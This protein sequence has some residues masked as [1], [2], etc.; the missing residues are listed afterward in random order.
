MSGFC[1]DGV[2]CTTACDGPAEQCDLSGREGD[3][4]AFA[5]APAASGWALSTMGAVLIAIAA[6]ALRQLTR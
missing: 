2:C 5:P 4:V 1:V 3:C 6:L